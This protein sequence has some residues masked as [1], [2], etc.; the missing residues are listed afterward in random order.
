VDDDRGE[1]A[2][3]STMLPLPEF[4]PVSRIEWWRS[5]GMHYVCPA[6]GHLVSNP[7]GRGCP[8]HGVKL[9][10]NCRVCRKP[11]KL[12]SE[13]MYSSRATD[14]A[15]FCRF[16]FTPA[17][18][19]GR[20]ELMAWVR[21]QVQADGGLSEGERAELVAVLDRIKDMEPSDGNAVPGWRRLHDLAPK[22][23]AA[24]KPVREALM[25]EGV[26]RALDA[27]FG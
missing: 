20:R 19:L 8:E 15:K 24:T 3:V 1:G 23:F 14:G 25:S 2:M 11:W 12:V 16:C 10:L 18:W 6:T 27:L 5:R 26:R 22:V 4:F 13:S 17:P 7:E 21:H 9:F